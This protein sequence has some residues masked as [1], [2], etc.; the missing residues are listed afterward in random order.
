MRKEIG[1]RVAGG[2]VHTVRPK[3]AIAPRQRVQRREDD[4]EDETDERA[5]P[6]PGMGQLVDKS[7]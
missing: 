1:T 4:R 6:P 5:P 3:T 2:G 7:V